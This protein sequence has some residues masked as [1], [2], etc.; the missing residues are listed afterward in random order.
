M[1]K[2]FPLS[3][4]L[5]KIFNWNTVKLSYNLM[6][7]VTSLI[8][9]SNTKK[10]MNNQHTESSR[11]NCT[12]KANYCLK[13]KSQFEC[14][15]YKVEVHLIGLVGRVFANVPGDLG[16]IQG[17]IIPKTLKMVLDT[18]LLNTQGTYQG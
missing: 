16:S 15:V 5:Y 11:C 7:N 4:S 13:G 18:S 3:S 12:N 10:Q 1:E 17:R 8:N 14:I 6:P 9:K 2:N